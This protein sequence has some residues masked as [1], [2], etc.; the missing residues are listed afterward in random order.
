MNLAISGDQNGWGI[1]WISIS[2][3]LFGAH[4]VH[5][6]HSLH[7]THETDIRFFGCE[8]TNTATHNFSFWSKLFEKPASQQYQERMSTCADVTL[9]R[10]YWWA[11][12]N[13]NCNTFFMRPTIS[14][15]K[16]Q[17]T[18]LVIIRLK[19]RNKSIRSNLGIMYCYSSNENAKK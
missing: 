8:A 5:C 18:W 2:D 16:M 1:I 19:I 15:I 13:T 6:G 3:H 12:S 14:H 9:Y 4:S 7:R 10:I 11:V 17:C